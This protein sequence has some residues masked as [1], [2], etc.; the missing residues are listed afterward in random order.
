MNDPPGVPS[1]L[2]IE[3]VEWFSEGGEN[4][5][6][7]VTGRWR[8]RR[9][10]WSAQPTLVIEAPGRRYRFPAMPEPPSLS[11]TPPGMWRI[12]FSV[13]AALAADLG[14][15][16][17]LQFGAVVVPLPAA[18]EPPGAGGDEPEL[19]AGDESQSE[20][21][22]PDS[23]PVAEADQPAPRP[24][25]SAEL[26]AE[27]ARRRTADAEQAATGVRA[28]VGGLEQQLEGARAEVAELRRSVT[29]LEATR[30]SAEQR[31]HA[32]RAQRFDLE[33]RLADRVREGDRARQALGDLA[34]AE[35]RLRELERELAAARRRIDEADQVAATATAARE[36]AEQAVTE[37]EDELERARAQRRPVRAP[38]ELER[39]LGAE[40]EL[41]A[42]RTGSVRRVPDEPALSAIAMAP[43]PAS[44]DP[45]AEALVSALR[46]EL[47][48]RAGA[49]AALRARLVDAEARVA[50]RQV[51]DERIRATVAQL[52]DELDGLRGTV[53][54]ERDGRLVAERR[55]ATLELEL[56]RLRRRTGEAHEA[57][58]EL[59]LAL[60][61]LR[62]QEPAAG[63]EPAEVEVEVESAAEPEA[64]VGAEP[65]VEVVAEPEPEAPPTTP[66][67][68]PEAEPMER[69]SEALVRL[70]DGIAPL[71]EPETED[72]PGSAAAA[73]VKLPPPSGEPAPPAEPTPETTSWLRPVFTA[74]AKDDPDRAGRLIVDL[75]PA[76]RAVDPEPVAYDVMLG[77]EAG[78]MRVTVDGSGHRVVHD[79]VPRRRREVDFQV[80][81]GYAELTA[82]LIAS[83]VRRR[84]GRG[85]ARVRGKRKRLAAFEALP[86][87]RLDLKGLHD[88]GVRMHPLTLLTVLASA[89]KPSWTEGVRFTLAYESPPEPTAYLLVGDGPGAQVRDDAPPGPVSTRVSGP[90]GSLELLLAG[91]PGEETVVIGDELPLTQIAEWIKRAQSA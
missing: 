86:D 63:T 19:E 65:V 52:R 12:S 57:I 49:E 59:R 70:R 7:R 3:V 46:V 73:A 80:I 66:Q 38:E 43:V 76:Q 67:A 13:P 31:A 62:G 8:R 28:Q 34:A 37:A 1:P 71:D 72:E 90:L 14:G 89:I 29:G 10:A 81:G 40:H 39:L 27:D 88:T 33:Q 16:A 24:L 82:M 18:V 68:R 55:V 9:P 64:V 56:G 60:E 75:L 78:C 42:R 30:R 22:Q 47:D 85:V 91:T 20:D 45:G 61:L 53:G 32:E 77:G 15:R 87:A 74:L 51:L 54:R 44:P 5:T 41:K 48:Q 50:A 23:E 83:P 6:V 69:L 35:E 25:P 2:G 84:F 11:G 79:D 21:P 26:E 4:L 17:W 58:G 36:R